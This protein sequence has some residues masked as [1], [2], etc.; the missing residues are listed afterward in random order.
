MH[1]RSLRV[2]VRR[3]ARAPTPRRR[4]VL[5]DVRAT[6][7]SMHRRVEGG[8]PTTSRATSS[9]TT[10][11]S[12]TTS[13]RTSRSATTSPP[14]TPRSCQEMIDRWWAEAGRFDVLPLDGRRAHRALPQPTVPARH[15]HEPDSIRLSPTGVA[16]PGQHD[17][18]DRVGRVSVRADIDVPDDPPGEG[19]DGALLNR[20]TINGGFAFLVTRRAPDVPLQQ[21]PSAQSR[22]PHQSRWLPA[23]DTSRFASIRSA[24]APAASRCRSTTKM[25]P[26]AAWARWSA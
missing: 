7:R 12:S 24:T 21:L 10:S 3:R 25:S 15:A 4:A 6:A 11:G 22:P 2:D 8:R 13:T 18:S 14:S 19:T 23:P 20:G 9:T 5:R 16:P 1:G 26:R 17:T